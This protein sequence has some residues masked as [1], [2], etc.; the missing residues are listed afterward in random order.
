LGKEGSKDKKIY[1]YVKKEEI[2]KE[3]EMYPLNFIKTISKGFC[4]EIT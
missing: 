3:K 4:Y 1:F 2:Y